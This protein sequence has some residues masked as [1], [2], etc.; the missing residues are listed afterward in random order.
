MA[1]AERRPSRPHQPAVRAGGN[2][3]AQPAA[4]AIR[5]AA[6]TKKYG[7]FTAVDKLDLTVRAR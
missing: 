2:Q 7:D 3:A 1:V 4:P 6:L 5:T